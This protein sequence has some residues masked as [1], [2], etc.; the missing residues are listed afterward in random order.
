M[1]LE[2]QYRQNGKFIDYTPAVAVTGGEVIQLADGRAAVAH[3]D[4][5]AGALGSVQVEG[6]YTCQK[7]TSMVILDGGRVYWDHSANKAHY[8]AVNDRDFYLGVAVGDAAS[9]DTTLVVDLNVQQ[10]ATIDALHGPSLSV[11]TG[12]A[13]AGGFGLPAVYGGSLGLRLTATNEAQCVDILSVDRVAIAAKP[14]LEAIFRLGANG[15]TSDVDINIGLANGTST[16]DAGAITERVF[17]HIDGGSLDIRAESDDGT[18]EVSATDTTVDA[19]AGSAVSDRVEV[20]MDARNPADIQIYVNGALV[21]PS[22]VFTLAAATGPI[23][24]LAHVEKS[25]G[26]A[27]AGPVY[28]DRLMIRTAQQ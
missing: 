11:A 26:T 4:I 18:T 20:W 14:I 8:K 10:V 22:T 27:T 1:P 24:A 2:A 9:A 16:T 5:A 15:S 23:G 3:A 7:T 19:T 12:T 28:I 6:H 13:A 25:S 17:I 21:L